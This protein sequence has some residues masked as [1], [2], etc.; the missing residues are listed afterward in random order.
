[1]PPSVSVTRTCGFQEQ[2]VDVLEEQPRA[3]LRDER[4]EAVARILFGIDRQRLLEQ[5]LELV[6]VLLA[7]DDAGCSATYGTWRQAPLD[8][9][10]A[11][12]MP[13]RALF[14][15]AERV[16]LA[17]DRDHQLGNRAVVPCFVQRQRALGKRPHDRPVDQQLGMLDAAGRDGRAERGRRPVEERDMFLLR[18]VERR[19]GIGLQLRLMPRN[20]TSSPRQQ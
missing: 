17:L 15:A 5:L 18:A 1:M 13:A 4:H 8:L 3:L 19:D 14:G 6:T 9:D 2:V 16:A 7:L 10:G 12:E 11:R 20:V